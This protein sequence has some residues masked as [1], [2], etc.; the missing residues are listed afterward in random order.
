MLQSSWN[1][2]MGMDPG[3][4]WKWKIGGRK[5]EDPERSLYS[6]KQGHAMGSLTNETKK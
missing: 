1:G 3:W 4:C 5:S 6:V 2:S